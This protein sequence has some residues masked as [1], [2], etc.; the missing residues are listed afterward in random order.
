MATNHSA[1][2]VF[3]LTAAIPPYIERRGYSK[4]YVN[5]LNEVYNNLNRYCEDHGYSKFTTELAQQFLRDRYRLQPGTIERRVSRQVRAMD[6]LLDFQHCGA[7]MIRRRKEKI[8]PD[9]FATH[10]EEY[11]VHMKNSYAQPNTVE[12]HR[13]TIY[14]F[15][16]FIDCRGV[17][18][19]DKLTLDDVNAFIKMTLCNYSTASARCYFGILRSFLRYLHR[20]GIIQNDL[21]KKVVSVPEAPHDVHLPS[22]L[23]LDQIEAILKCVDCESPMGKRDYAILLLAARLGLRASDIRNLK[24]SDISWETNEIRITQVKTRN[25]LVLPL[26][27]DVGWAIIDYYKNARPQND[28]PE[29]FLRVVAPHVPLKNPDNVLI[30]YMREAKIPYKRLSHHGLHILRHSLATHML[31]EDVDITTIQGVLGHLNIATTEK[32][33]GINVRQLKECALEVASL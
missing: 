12:S 32:Y 14:R 13:K 15:T 3:Q 23:S 25:P 27:R 19:Y 18:S 9:Q 7:V 17:N 4:G 30:R 8:F 2:D 31:D 16:D 26:P 6:M 1:M 20:E 21:S 24:E 10:A 11:F 28:V 33:I 22:T 5:G 29:L